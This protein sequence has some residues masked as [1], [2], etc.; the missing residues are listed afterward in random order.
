MA[1]ERIPKII[2]FIEGIEATPE[3]LDAIAELGEGV[4]IR[5]AVKAQPDASIE[6]FDRV[7]GAVPEHYAKSDGKPQP[8]LTKRAKKLA[9]MEST[10]ERDAAID[11]TRPATQRR[12]AAKGA[13][14]PSAPEPAAGPQGSAWG[15]PPAGTSASPPAPAAAPVWKPNA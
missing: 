12:G 3:E 11:A 1:K 15:A 2:F 10:R 9:R 8:F 5:S 6:T 14:L 13:A 4:V 7:E